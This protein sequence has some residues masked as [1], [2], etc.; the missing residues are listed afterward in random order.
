M[1]WLPKNSMGSRSL[2]SHR[3]FA[4]LSAVGLCSRSSRGEWL[5]RLGSRRGEEAGRRGFLLLEGFYTARRRKKPRSR[6]DAGAS[7]F[8]WGEP[9]AMRGEH[10]EALLN[11]FCCHLHYMPVWQFR[12]ITASICLLKWYVPQF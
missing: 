7:G 9:V 11:A 5:T 1:S 10:R 2:S 8:H 3:D 4:A 6:G 12:R